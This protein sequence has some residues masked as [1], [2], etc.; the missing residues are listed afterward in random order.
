MTNE[1][2]PS[3]NGGEGHFDEK[4]EKRKDVR[5]SNI[6]AG[7]AVADAVRTSLGPRGM[8]KMIKKPGGEVVITN[9]G[10]TILDQMKVIHPA[11]KMLVD[12]SKAQDVEAGDG[13]TSVVVLCGS[14][15]AACEQ[16]LTKG[17]HPT[18]IAESFLKANLFA[19]NTLKGNAF[20]TIRS[21]QYD[22]RCSTI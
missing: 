2:A 22:S 4:S 13:T 16:L 15:L 6:V 18:T 12:L 11:A 8:D 7:K 5:A 3:H 9:D 21:V 17:I 1:V 20:S 14:L 19:Q 10:A